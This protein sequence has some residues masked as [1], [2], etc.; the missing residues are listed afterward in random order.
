MESLEAMQFLEVME[1]TWR[2][3]RVPGGDGEYLEVMEFLV[4]G[5]DVVVGVLEARTGGGGNGV[6]L[7][8]M[9]SLRESMK[10]L[11]AME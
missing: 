7:E 5:C 8:A 6:V 9:K 4:P 11:E 1:S 10:S 3:W 2:R